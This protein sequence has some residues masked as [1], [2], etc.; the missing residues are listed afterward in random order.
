MSGFL[1]AA[2]A[3]SHKSSAPFD[4]RIE[5]DGCWLVLIDDWTGNV[6]A[7]CQPDRDI[8]EFQR[9]GQKRLFDPL[10]YRKEGDTIKP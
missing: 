9:R 8:W 2:A 10:P 4:I 1:N 6:L 7:R 5:W 3:Q